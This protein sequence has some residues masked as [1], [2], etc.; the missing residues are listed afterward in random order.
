MFYVAQARRAWPLL[1]A[2]VVAV[3]DALSIV[4]LPGSSSPLVGAARFGAGV[5]AVLVVLGYARRVSRGRAIRA[6]G[7]VG[8]RDALSTSMA[9]G[10]DQRWLGRAAGT[11]TASRRGDRLGAGRRVSRGEPPS[12]GR[13]V[14]N[15]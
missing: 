14:P 3:S 5:G 13:Q 15:P 8:P 7:L 1:I 12:T 11:L 9:R 6:V 2:W 10:R 4:V